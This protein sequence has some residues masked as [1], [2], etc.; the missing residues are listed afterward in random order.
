M[1]VEIRSTLVLQ[2]GAVDIRSA[3]VLPSGAVDIRSTLADLS[4]TRTLSLSL[5]PWELLG[6]RGLGFSI[7][8]IRSTNVLLSGTV[9]V[10]SNP[11]I[12][13]LFAHL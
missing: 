10:R 1:I 12:H 3:L 5:A 9:D 11:V 8:E 2:S 13:R 4:L 7:V 6:R